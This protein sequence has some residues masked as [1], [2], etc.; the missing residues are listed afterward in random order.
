MNIPVHWKDAAK[1]AYSTAIAAPMSYYLENYGDHGYNEA[2]YQHLFLRELKA[3]DLQDTYTPI[4]GAASYSLLYHIVRSLV[5]VQ[6]P[7]VLELGAGQSSLLLSACKGV[8]F[9]GDILTIEQDKGWAEA[10]SRR[11]GH[12]VRHVPV[13]ISKVGFSSTLRYEGLKTRL[14]ERK[15][16]VVVVDGPTGSRMF[17]RS[18]ILDLVPNLSRDKFVVIFDDTNRFGEKQVVRVLSEKLRKEFEHVSEY[19]IRSSRHQSVFLHNVNIHDLY[20]T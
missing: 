4:G 11:V 15:F 9:G 6:P 14:G 2:I 3:H 13:G 5:C 8:V 19:T 10:I 16:G 17:S 7:Q 20:L 18:S 12:E 1:W